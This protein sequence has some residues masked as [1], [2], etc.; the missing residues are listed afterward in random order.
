VAVHPPVLVSPPVVAVL[1]LVHYP[2]KR[3]NRVPQEVTVTAEALVAVHAAALAS[4][5]VDP[6]VQET[7]L[8]VVYKAYKELQVEIL[9]ALADVAVQVAAF[10]SNPVDVAVHGTQTPV[11]HNAYSEAQVV[12]ETV[13]VVGEVHAVALASNPVDPDVA[14]VHDK[15]FAFDVRAKPVTHPV[16]TTVAA[17]EEVHVA[18]LESIPVFVAVQERQVPENNA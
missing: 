7:H 1:Q 18:A 11:L 9:T 2:L 14:T 12:T 13:E 5:P 6:D 17:T 16:T 10:A 15:H 8:V 4:N 3:A